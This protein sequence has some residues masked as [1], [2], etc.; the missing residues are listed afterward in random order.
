MPD[1]SPK[2][3]A[4]IAS[5]THG[6]FQLSDVPADPRDETAAAAAAASAPEAKASTH[7]KKK[8]R[9]DAAEAD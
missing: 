9:A 7:P 1:L 2:E 3:T 5:G 4:E 8:A 6:E